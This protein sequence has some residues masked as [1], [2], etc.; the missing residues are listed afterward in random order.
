M[1]L[2]SILFDIIESGI[3]NADTSDASLK[4]RQGYRSDGKMDR[5]TNEYRDARDRAAY[6][7]GY[8]TGKNTPRT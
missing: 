5:R 1:G 8:K 6:A 2:I 3:D 4:N 7:R